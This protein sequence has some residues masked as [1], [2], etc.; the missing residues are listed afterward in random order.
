MCGPACVQVARISKATGQR[1]RIDT[2]L[3]VVLVALWSQFL[4]ALAAPDALEV[5]EHIIGDLPPTAISRLLPSDVMKSC[6][7]IS[8]KPIG[9]VLEQVRRMH[10]HRLLQHA[11]ERP[12]RC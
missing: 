7:H 3:Q 6:L 4:A 8:G 2:A 5:R 12:C 11:P 1:Q 10:C 9:Q